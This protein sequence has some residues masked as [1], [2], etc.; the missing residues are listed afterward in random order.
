VNKI[1]PSGKFFG[2][3]DASMAMSLRNTLASIQMD[4]GFGLLNAAQNDEDAIWVGLAVGLSIPLVSLIVKRL[5]QSA[6]N[7]LKSGGW[8]RNHEVAGGHTLLKHVEVDDVTLLLRLQAEPW[9]PAAS[10]FTSQEIAER[11]IADAIRQH[12]TEVKL[13]L[14]SNSMQNLPLTY[15]DS[16]VIGRGILNGQ[17]TAQPMSN[18]KIIL[19]KNGKGYHILTAYPEP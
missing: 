9:I 6:K 19:K 1:D 15:A 5:V 7:V 10:T 3:A 2:L 17:A 12:R 4:F 18:A 8:L 11:V 16:S 14:R 13:W